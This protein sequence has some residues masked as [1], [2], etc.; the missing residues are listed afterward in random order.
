M[1]LNKTVSF[2]GFELNYWS[3]VERTW[4]KFSNTT[5]AELGCFKNEATAKEV[6]NGKRVGL[7]NEILALRKSFS[8]SG[9]LSVQDCYPL[10][11][12]SRLVKGV[13]QNFF[14]DALDC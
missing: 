6:V 14:A 5:R 3:I 2:K 13:E 9:D 7:G 12:A 4:D 8:F 10:V 11:K 1:A